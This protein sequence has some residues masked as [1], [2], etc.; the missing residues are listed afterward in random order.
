MNS[1]TEAKAYHLSLVHEACVQKRADQPR[2]R[3]LSLRL[4]LRVP[5]G[6]WK[7]GLLKTPVVPTDPTVSLAFLAHA[8]TLLCAM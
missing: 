5:S 6:C 2:T 4:E 1:P 3:I 8:A 7:R